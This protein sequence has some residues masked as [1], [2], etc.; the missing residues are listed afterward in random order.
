MYLRKEMIFPL[1]QIESL[2]LLKIRSGFRSLACCLLRMNHASPPMCKPELT[3]RF[4]KRDSRI[5]LFFYSFFTLC[6]FQNSVSTRKYLRHLQKTAI[7][8]PQRF[9]RKSSRLPWKERASSDSP[10]LEPV[11]LLP[12]L[13]RFSRSSM[14]ISENL[15]LSFSLRLVSL[16]CRSVKSFSSSPSV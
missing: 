12:S 11:R 8:K 4:F 10:R 16:Q 6:Y 3:C 5:S 13:S 1:S 9:R 7:L 14:Q 2:H 15:R